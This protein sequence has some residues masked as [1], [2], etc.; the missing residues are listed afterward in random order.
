MKGASAIFAF[1][2]SHG[3]TVTV[4]SP[5]PPER[6]HPSE[7]TNFQI[8]EEPIL[9]GLIGGISVSRIEIVHPMV[10]G[11]ED[12]HYQIWPVDETHSWIERFGKQATPK[13]H[14]R[15]V[16]ADFLDNIMRKS[17]IVDL[18][19]ENLMTSAMHGG[20]SRPEKVR[21][22]TLLHQLT[23]LVM[24]LE[25]KLNEGCSRDHEEGCSENKKMAEEREEKEYSEEKNEG[26]EE[27]QEEGRGNNKV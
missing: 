12:F 18:K 11:A 17:S 21:K 6:F 5:P 16:K 1:Y 2:I 8:I 27:N 7:Q 25:T 19:P 15:A 23:L 14:W 22:L 24:W 13:P 26:E 4:L 10:K 3:D 20:A 9:K